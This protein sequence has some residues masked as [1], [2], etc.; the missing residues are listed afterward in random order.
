MI[1]NVNRPTTYID[2]NCK[3]KQYLRGRWHWIEAEALYT[4]KINCKT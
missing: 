3:K 4:L 2:V 1:L